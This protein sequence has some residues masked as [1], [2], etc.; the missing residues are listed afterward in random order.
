MQDQNC[1]A[2]NEPLIQPKLLQCGHICCQRCI[3][4]SLLF[5]DDGS[6]SMKCPKDECVLRTTLSSSETSNDL[7]TFDISTDTVEDSSLVPQC[8]NIDGCVMPVTSYC[9]RLKMCTT[10]YQQHV[11]SEGEHKKVTLYFCPVD[12]Q[13]KGYCDSHAIP[14]SHVC[15]CDNT[16]LCVYCVHRNV[17]HREHEKNTIHHES[18][19]IRKALLEDYGRRQRM[20]EYRKASEAQISVS[21]AK[22]QEVLKKRKEECLAQYTAYLN[23]EEEKIKD[24]FQDICGH[25]QRIAELS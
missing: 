23:A 18:A 13:L 19:V 8:R 22:L 15:S 16:L 2:C 21:R 4:K 7:Q 20:E 9:C 14:Y 11:E 24:K 17:D 10:C 12:K 3:D 1:S 25:V 6:A 5:D